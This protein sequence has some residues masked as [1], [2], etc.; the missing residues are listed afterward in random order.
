MIFD[1]LDR[2]D[3]LNLSEHLKP[4]VVGDWQI[5]YY[6]LTTEHIQVLKLRD[7]IHS[8]DELS[9]QREGIVVRL[10]NGDTTVMSDTAMERR[11]NTPFFLNAKGDILIAG[12]GLGV[13]IM[14][15]QDLPE[16]KSITVIERSSA[17]IELVTTQLPLNDKV[18]VIYDDIFKWKPKRRTRYDTI[19]F[20]IWDAICGDYY[21][22]MRLLRKRFRTYKRDKD[23]W[24]GHWRE[25]DMRIAA[26]RWGNFF[27]HL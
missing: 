5:D 19:Y 24:L 2:V 11:T 27:S 8:S 10:R 20:D 22:A 23:S 16:V 6:N 13:I 25:E 14:P 7:D 21:E 18:T 12:L 17:V 4:R 26:R 9:G 15:I 3:A 1:V